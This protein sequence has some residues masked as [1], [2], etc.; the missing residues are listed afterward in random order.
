M[1]LHCVPP[2][3]KT[4]AP[5][6]PFPALSSVFLP[7]C[8]ILACSGPLDVS[9]Q[10]SPAYP[11][12]L[13]VPNASTSLFFPVLSPPPFAPLGALDPSPNRLPSKPKAPALVQ[14]SPLPGLP[15]SSQPGDL[16]NS[17]PF[18]C[19]IIYHSPEHPKAKHCV[20]QAPLTRRCQ[21]RL[22]DSSHSIAA[23]SHFLRGVRIPPLGL[24][25][26]PGSLS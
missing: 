13:C 24:F 2:P 18:P 19:L 4:P 11:T 1:E 3:S 7:T 6:G 8:R 12:L 25:P 9:F 21:L 22:Y 5:D 14:P 10:V 20:T 26:L 16:S 23:F 17:V 15:H